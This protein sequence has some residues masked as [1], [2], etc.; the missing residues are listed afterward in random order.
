M[1]NNKKVKIFSGMA[2]F[3]L[4]IVTGLAFSVTYVVV[5][6]DK[7]IVYLEESHSKWGG[8]IA[9]IR[10]MLQNYNLTSTILTV[11]FFALYFVAFSKLNSSL[12]KS[13]LV[14]SVIYA[15]LSVI[16]KCFNDSGNMDFC[17]IGAGHFAVCVLFGISYLAFY[18]A[19]ISVLEW[20]M[21]KGVFANT[22]SWKVNFDH[23]THTKLYIFLFACI[24][25]LPNLFWFYPG[26]VNWDGLRQLDFWIGSLEWTT[27]HPAFSTVLMGA[28]F[29]VGKAIGGDDYGGFFLYVC[30]QIVC[31]AVLLSASMDILKKWGIGIGCRT[32]LIVY[33]SL[34]SIWQLYLITYIKD[35]S[36]YLAVWWF[37]IIIVNVLNEREKVRSCH[38]ICLVTSGFLV[39]MLR[40]DGIF[41]VIPTIVIL[42]V[43]LKKHVQKCLN[44]IAVIMFG[45]IFVNVFLVNAL[46]I[47]KGD[48]KEALSIPFQQTARYVKEYPKDVT[49]YERRVIDKLLLF[50]ELGDRY[51]PDIS[52]PVKG[53][54]Y[55]PYTK[56]D[57]EDYFYVW[58]M[59]FL[60]HPVCYMECFLNGSYRYWY[61]GAAPYLNSIGTYTQVTSTYVDRGDFEFQFRENRQDGRK[62]IE[63]AD[64]IG[65]KLPVINM[66]Y[67]PSTYIWIMIFG[68]YF[69]IRKREFDKLT[70]Y[71]PVAM[72]FLIN[73]ASPLNGSIR[74]ALP[75]MVA[76]PFLTVYAL[77]K[78]KVNK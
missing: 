12:C 10:Y 19:I 30:I 20:C 8:I 36:Y 35:T 52:D 59:Q 16:G 75:V 38:F 3:I 55:D 62:I 77:K 43:K 2:L 40:N 50:D 32:A 69:I 70:A 37:V 5:P 65:Y 1:D 72:C 74:Y 47:G 23:L 61:I 57:L 63:N 49:E 13:R 67:R 56:A 4:S 6:A 11:S 28:V 7:Y 15:L 18:Y 76:I 68:I 48:I 78:E 14:L 31:H 17:F 29:E 45:Y 21:E 66:L 46:S 9:Q 22:I 44:S 58:W 25:Q 54:R 60:K 26:I 64:Y 71:V 27:H 53:S 42:G 33:Y 41:V 24:S 73:V 39:V 34:F 51:N